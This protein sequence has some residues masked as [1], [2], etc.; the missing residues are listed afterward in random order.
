MTAPRERRGTTRP[1]EGSLAI[2]LDGGRVAVSRAKHDAISFTP[3]PTVEHYDPATNTWSSFATLAA[4][5]MFHTA[6]TLRDGRVF[7]TGG[8][9]AGWNKLG[10]TELIS[11]QGTVSAGPSMSVPRV[12]PTA[13]LLQLSVWGLAELEP[14]LRGEFLLGQGG[15]SVEEGEFYVGSRCAFP[16]A[17]E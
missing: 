3:T 7:V 4:A 14:L 16:P 15:F 1:G 10:T 11:P 12:G 5:R 17:Q 13:T 9:N 8:T 6:T 2:H